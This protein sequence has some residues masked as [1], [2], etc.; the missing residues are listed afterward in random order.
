MAS[1]LHI[2]QMNTFCIVILSFATILNLKLVSLL[3]FFVLTCKLTMI[4]TQN[5]NIIRRY[6]TGRSQKYCDN[7]KIDEM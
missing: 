2:Y 4:S 3:R 5:I 7:T 1:K 6:D